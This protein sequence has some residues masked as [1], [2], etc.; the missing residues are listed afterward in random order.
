[1]RA[2]RDLETGS[3]WLAFVAF[4]IGLAMLLAGVALVVWGVPAPHSPIGYLVAVAGAGAAVWG[5]VHLPRTFQL[6]GPFPPGAAGVRAAGAAVFLL[7]VILAL[8]FV[9]RLSR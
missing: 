4:M 1:M 8:L 7:F 3:G 5:A 6:G 9:A 2:S